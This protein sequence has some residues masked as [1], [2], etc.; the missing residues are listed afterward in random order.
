VLLDEPPRP[1]RVTLRDGRDELAFRH[2]DNAL[3]CWESLG[4]MLETW[5]EHGWVIVA[6]QRDHAQITLTT[7]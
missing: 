7:I 3:F 6:D 5:T 1:H 4:G 2:F